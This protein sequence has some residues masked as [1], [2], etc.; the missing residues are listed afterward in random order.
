MAVEWLKKIFIP[1][2]Q[3]SRPQEKRLLIMDGHRSHETTDFMFLC[4][5]HNIYLLYLPAHTSHILQPLDLSV[6]SSLKRSY[7]KELGYLNIL[8]DSSPLGKQ[9]FLLCYQKA[10]KE[11]LT[12]SNIKSGWKASCYGSGGSTMAD[13]P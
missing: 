10:R 6:F 4:L 9:N 5:Q 11:A 3:P 13:K 12:I 8:T 7:R 1:W 2:T